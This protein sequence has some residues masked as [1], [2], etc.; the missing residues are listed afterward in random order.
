MAGYGDVVIKSN[1]KFIKIEAGA[2]QDLRILDESPSELFKHASKQGPV[3]CLGEN[4]CLKCASGDSPTQKFVTNV[5]SHNM[6]KV[7]LWEYGGG[8]AKQLKSIAQTLEEENKTILDVDLKVDATGS[9]KEKRYQVTP[10][11]T[12]K[13]IPQNLTLHKLQNNDISF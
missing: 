12:A 3:S 1:S 8:V 10:R 4:T 13:P 11:M 6:N 9:G 7:L 5:Y 2:P